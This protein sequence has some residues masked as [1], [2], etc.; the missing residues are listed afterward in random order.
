MSYVSVAIGAGSFEHVKE[1]QPGAVHWDSEGRVGQVL[2]QMYVWAEP[3]GGVR[4]SFCG[5]VL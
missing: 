4:G 2:G 3:E 1:R 5:Y